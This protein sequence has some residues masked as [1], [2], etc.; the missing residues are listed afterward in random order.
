M[1][2]AEVHKPDHPDAR[3]D[4]YVAHAYTNDTPIT[5]MVDCSTTSRS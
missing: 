4:G 1:N 2:L 5:E 3:A